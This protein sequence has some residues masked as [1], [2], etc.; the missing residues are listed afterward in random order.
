MPS[1][2]RS[3]VRHVPDLLFKAN[4]AVEAP[5]PSSLPI[6]NLRMTIVVIYSCPL[7]GLT[8]EHHD[9]EHRH[10]DSYDRDWTTI[11]A[12]PLGSSQAM[13]SPRS[14]LRVEMHQTCLNFLRKAQEDTKYEMIQDERLARCCL[15]AIES[16]PQLD[17]DQ[18]PEISEVDL[19]LVL[20]ASYDHEAENSPDTPP[21]FSPTVSKKLK[22][23]SDDTLLIFLDRLKSILDVVTFLAQMQLKKE[24]VWCLV[25]IQTSRRLHMSLL[26]LGRPVTTKRALEDIWEAITNR[27]TIFRTI[28]SL[29][30][31]AQKPLCG[32]TAD[33]SCLTFLSNTLRPSIF[34][35]LELGPLDTSSTLVKIHLRE[36]AGRSYVVGLNVGGVSVGDA[37]TWTREITASIYDLWVVYDWNGVF[38]LCSGS[39]LQAVLSSHADTCCYRLLQGPDEQLRAYFDVSEPCFCLKASLTT[40]PSFNLGAILPMGKS[41]KR[42][43]WRG[44]PPLGMDMDIIVEPRDTNCYWEWIILPVNLYSILIHKNGESEARIIGIE[45]V[46]T[47]G[48]ACMLGHKW[49]ECEKSWVPESP[50]WGVRCIVD[51]VLQHLRPN[52]HDL[53]LIHVL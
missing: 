6:I 47:V 16:R 9:Y 33:T 10:L 20:N 52:S 12:P 5:L 8:V 32:Q 40:Q 17:S 51:Q 41:H 37:R 2:F 29:L 1:E 50:V 14:D 30:G 15:D 35:K 31:V 36:F 46:D 38:D 53:T 11:V 27:E 45:I 39:H 22:T 49:F 19:Y 25:G 7:C 4:A 44:L 23:C 21:L 13:Q 34:D 28:H 42:P 3:F 26:P 18:D 43:F 24:D 48:N